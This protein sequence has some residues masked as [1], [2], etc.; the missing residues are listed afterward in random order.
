MLRID[1]NFVQAHIDVYHYLYDLV[2][3]GG[4][5]ILDDAFVHAR[6]FWRMLEESKD[7][8]NRTMPELQ[9]I[10]SWGG[11]YRKHE[12]WNTDRAWYEKHTPNTKERAIAVTFGG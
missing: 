1:G 6:R 8:E 5:V 9:R 10:D 3:I 12:H 7:A 11:W 2:P 4:M